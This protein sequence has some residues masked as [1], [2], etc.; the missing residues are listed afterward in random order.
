MSII[1]SIN[2]VMFDD[3][4]WERECDRL[5]Y[6][7]QRKLKV[8]HSNSKKIPH[9]NGHYIYRQKNELSEPDEFK[10]TL[11]N[12]DTGVFIGGV[13]KYCKFKGERAKRS[14]KQEEQPAE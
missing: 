3:K 13:Y 12:V 5:E 10:K 1:F 11:I 7:T 4:I 8:H 2:I 6:L 9:E 14:D